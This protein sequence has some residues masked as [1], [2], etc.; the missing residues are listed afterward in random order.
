MLLNELREMFDTHDRCSS[1]LIRHK[2]LC[3][4]V[5]EQYARVS[6]SYGRERLVGES[7]KRKLD[8][9]HVTSR[10]QQAR[11]HETSPILLGTPQQ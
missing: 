9:R 7:G 4:V 3:T 2:I 8:R 5:G 11:C 1:L 6:Q 10:A